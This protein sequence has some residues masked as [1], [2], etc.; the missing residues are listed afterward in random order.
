[1]PKTLELKTPAAYTDISDGSAA[2]W[3]TA[4]QFTVEIEYED[5]GKSGPLLKISQMPKR[6]VAAKS[7]DNWFSEIVSTPGYVAK[8]LVLFM[9]DNG[10]AASEAENLLGQ[11]DVF[12]GSKN[13]KH[14][15][16]RDLMLE[17]ATKSKISYDTLKALGWFILPLNNMKI[18]QNG[19]R[20]EVRFSTAQT[21]WDICG[22]FVEM[23]A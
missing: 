14:I 11:L 5:S 10:T 23:Q 22:W 12:Q 15:T 6:A 18:P 9:E 13:I 21:A 19:L 17:T 7:Y 16:L 3:T 1:V 20:F 2:S 4:P 8:C